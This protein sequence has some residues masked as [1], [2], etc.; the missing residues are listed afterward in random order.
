NGN[1][2]IC[3]GCDGRI[4]EVTADGQVVWE[5][6]NPH[7]SHEAGRPGLNNWVFR[8]RERH[9]DR[10]STRLNSSH[11]AISYAVFC[12]KKKKILRLGGSSQHY[13]QLRGIATMLSQGH[14][15]DA[16]DQRLLQDVLFGVRA[17]QVYVGDIV[18]LPP[19]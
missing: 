6:V 13:R 12:L 2:L 14:L 17:R 3:E 19:E 5:F 11:V 7:V 18:F 10:K 1:T 4:F 9:A 8:L 16:A 15:H